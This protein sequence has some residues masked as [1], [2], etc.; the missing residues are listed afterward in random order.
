[1]RKLKGY[2][3]LSWARRM[4][5][6]EA[7]VLLAIAAVAIACVPFRRLARYLGA[8]MEFDT[9]TTTERAVV[10]R[11]AVGWAVYVAARNFPWVSSCFARAVAAKVML[12]RRAI[13]S[14]LYLGVAPEGAGMLAHAWLRSGPVLVTG[15]INREFVPVCWFG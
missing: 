5:L 2:L 4:L 9:G 6:L 15:A 3:R 10:E 13:S 1:M 14:T 7:G 12:R 11:E 8:H